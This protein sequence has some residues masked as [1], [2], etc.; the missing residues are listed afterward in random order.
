MS[1]SSQFLIKHLLLNKVYQ[2]IL[3]KIGNR[4]VYLSEFAKEFKK[5]RETIWGQLKRLEE[6][7]FIVR[8]VNGRKVFFSV[9]RL[10]VTVCIDAYLNSLMNAYFEI[11]NNL[12]KLQKL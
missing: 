8:R 9:N 2:D 3:I 6:A 4:E 11:K 10:L 12:S 1:K 7:G 5:N